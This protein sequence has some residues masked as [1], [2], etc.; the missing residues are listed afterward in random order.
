ML[1]LLHVFLVN[2][3]D[4]CSDSSSFWGGGEAKLLDSFSKYALPGGDVQYVI[5]SLLC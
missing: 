1:L 2:R 5:V 4:T 3:K